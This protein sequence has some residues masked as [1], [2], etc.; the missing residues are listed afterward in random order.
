MIDAENRLSV[1]LG[2]VGKKR[3]NR[4]TK[5]YSQ[6]IKFLKEVPTPEITIID[7]SEENENININ[8]TNDFYFPSSLFSKQNLNQDDSEN[9]SLITPLSDTYRRFF[10]FNSESFEE[11]IRIFCKISLEISLEEG[12]FD[13][14]HKDILQQELETRPDLKNRLKLFANFVFDPKNSRKVYDI[15]FNIPNFKVN[16]QQLEEKGTIVSNMIFFALPKYVL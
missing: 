3:K 5:L 6:I 2:L 8:P 12:I 7:E 13:W 4:E 9:L 11:M 14:S 15:L 10:L 1:Y 16:N